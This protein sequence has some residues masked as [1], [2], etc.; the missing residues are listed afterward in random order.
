MQVYESTMVRN[1]E[2][3]FDLIWINPYTFNTPD[4]NPN[5]IFTYNLYASPKYIIE[6]NGGTGLHY[7]WIKH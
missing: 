2:S 5:S 4:Y 1:G 7:K 3:S 6:I